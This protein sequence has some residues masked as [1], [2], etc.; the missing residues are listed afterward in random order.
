VVN[1]AFL[2]SVRQRALYIQVHVLNCCG[3]TGVTI[4]TRLQVE[5]KGEAAR[6]PTHQNLII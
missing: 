3:M 6:D 5:V 1:S 2:R 4:D